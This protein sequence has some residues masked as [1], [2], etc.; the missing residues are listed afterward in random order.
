MYG[1]CPPWAAFEPDLEGS[2]RI[3]TDGHRPLLARHARPVPR[4]AAVG[5]HRLRRAPTLDVA[6]DPSGTGAATATWSG[7]AADVDCALWNRPTMQP[8]E[9]NGDEAILAAFEATIAEGVR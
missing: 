6:D 7:T 1:G 4:H 3:T 5:R 8:I 2:L 9:R